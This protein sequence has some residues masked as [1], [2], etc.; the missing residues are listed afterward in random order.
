M[1]GMRTMRMMMRVREELVPSPLR[2]KYLCSGWM[3]KRRRR[4]RRRREKMR[5]A[6][7]RRA[8]AGKGARRSLG[9]EQRTRRLRVERVVC[10]GSVGPVKVEGDKDVNGVEGGGTGGTNVT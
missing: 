4:R 2:R 8:V 10:V 3:M 6:V 1:M 5:T 7:R 9:G